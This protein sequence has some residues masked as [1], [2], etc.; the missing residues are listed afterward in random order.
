LGTG[1]GKVAWKIHSPKIRKALIPRPYRIAKKKGVPMTGLVDN[2]TREALES[3]TAPA[4]SGAAFISA[5]TGLYC[6]NTGS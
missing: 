3:K 1:K 4:N 6:L 5:N 2:I